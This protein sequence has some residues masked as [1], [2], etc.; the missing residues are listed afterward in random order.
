MDRM[1]TVM[2]N[3][4][5]RCLNY[6]VEVMFNMTEKFGNIRAALDVLSGEDKASFEAMRWFLVSMVN[7]AEL[8]RRDAGYDH[9]PMLKEE[10]ISLRM[11]PLEY[12]VLKAA[13]VDAINKGYMRETADE[14]QEIDLGLE[15]LRAKKAKAGD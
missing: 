8:Y 10:D 13:I 11:S 4:E 5:E 9:L 14:N 3:G 6:S 2:V 15:E 1:I 12:A 7:D